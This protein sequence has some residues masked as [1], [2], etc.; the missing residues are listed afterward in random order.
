MANNLLGLA[1]GPLLTG[2]IADH[3]SLQTAMQFVPVVGQLA[4]AAYFIGAKSCE[5]DRH[6]LQGSELR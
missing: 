5:E 6:R 4:A 1:P 3:S 2:W